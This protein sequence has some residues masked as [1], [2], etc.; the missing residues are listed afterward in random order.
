M[1]SFCHLHPLPLNVHSEKG[2]IRWDCIVTFPCFS[3]CFLQRSD[4]TMLGL[5]PEANSAKC[6]ELVLLNFGR[7]VL[8]DEWARFRDVHHVQCSRYLVCNGEQNTELF[9]FL[10]K[11]SE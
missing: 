3:L 1:I 4:L 8:G 9:F 10:Q 11:P 6:H 2:N 5:Q 7:D